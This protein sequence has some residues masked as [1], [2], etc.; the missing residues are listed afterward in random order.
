MKVLVVYAT[1]S[2]GTRIAATIIEEVLKKDHELTLTSIHDLSPKE[3]L[4]YDFIVLGSNSWFEKKEEGQ[5][6]SGFHTLKEKLQPDCWKG[7]K[8]AI[9]ALGDSNLY[10][11][12]FCKSADHLEKMVREFGGEAVVPPLRVDR[13]Y[14]NEEENERKITSWAEE[15]SQFLKPEQSR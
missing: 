4:S 3:V 14:F 7:K 1:Y 6:N 2:G 8:F 13:F 11:N 10:H 12:T 5:M 15:L 9:Y